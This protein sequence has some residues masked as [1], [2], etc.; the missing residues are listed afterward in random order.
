MPI[1]VRYGDRWVEFVYSG[2]V[3]RAEVEAAVMPALEADRATGRRLHRLHDLRAVAKWKLHFDEMASVMERNEAARRQVGAMRSAVVVA[4]DYQIG[5]AR[6][7]E[8]LAA[9]RGTV[10]RV[11]ADAHE[12][13][14]WLGGS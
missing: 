12:A 1:D 11:F 13:R 9:P 4:E 10:V 5:L 2:E 3:G 7:Y 14:A 8:A 6:Q